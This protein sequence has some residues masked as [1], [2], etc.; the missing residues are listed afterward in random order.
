MTQ[1]ER[2]RR[3]YQNNRE[4][5]LE[6]ARNQRKYE[7]AKLSPRRLIYQRL[8]GNAKARGIQFCLDLDDIVVPDKCPYLGLELKFGTGRP[9]HDS[10]SVDRVDSTKGYVKGNVEIISRLANM[11]KQDATPELLLRFAREVIKRYEVS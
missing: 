3:H 2:A 11:M 4:K 10:Y 5:Y 1:K 7:K 6:R 8:K 9:Q